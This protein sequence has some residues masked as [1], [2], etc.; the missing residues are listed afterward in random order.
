MKAARGI[1]LLTYRNYEILHQKQTDP[2]VN[3]LDHYKASSYIHHQGDKLV[4]RFNAYSYWILTKAMDSHNLARG[5][6]KLENVLKSISQPTLIIGITTDIL[7][8][9]REQRLLRDH[10]PNAKLVEIDSTYGH[11]GFLVEHERISKAVGDWLH[12]IV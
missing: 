5:R 2:D 10:I 7:C 12:S 6:D 9:L 8:P 1:G 4:N 3:K 11:D